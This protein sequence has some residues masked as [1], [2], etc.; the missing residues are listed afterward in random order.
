MDN[1]KKDFNLE[2]RNQET[3]SANGTIT[4]TTYEGDEPHLFVSYALEDE[5]IALNE[6]K[7]FQDMGYY[8]SYDKEKTQNNL[9]KIKKCWAYVVFFT[10]NSAKLN[11][12]IEEVQFAHENHKN[13]LPIFLVETEIDTLIEYELSESNRISK[14][15][16]DIET[17]LSKC[18]NSFKSFGIKSSNDS[19]DS[20]LVPGVG[21]VPFPAFRGEGSYMFISYAHKDSDIVFPEIKRFQDMGYNVWYDEGI[22]A[23]NE[24]LRDVLEHLV[25]SDLFVVFITN[26]SVKSKN[27]RKEIKFAVSKEKNIVP[28]YLENYDEINLDLQLDY[29][30]SQIQGIIKP[31]LDEEEYIFK[32]TEAFENFG[33]KPDYGDI[34]EKIEFKSPQELLMDDAL[35]NEVLYT[36]INLNTIKKYLDEFFNNLKLYDDYTKGYSYKEL[37]KLAIDVFLEKKYMYTA[38]DVYNTFFTI[39]QVNPSDE[40]NKKNINDKNLILDLINVIKNNY[41]DTQ[42]QKNLFIHSVNVFILGLAIYSRNKNYRNA[43][44]SYITGSEYEKYYKI[45]N[46][47]SDEEFLYRWGITSLLH[48]IYYPF[49]KNGKKENIR[50][51]KKLDNLLGQDQV[52]EDTTDLNNLVKKAP[53]DFTDKYV[54]KYEETKS[55]NLFKYTNIIAHKIYHNFKFDEEKLGLL[56]NHINNFLNEIK[57]T[58]FA[59][60]GFLSALL[61]LNAYDYQIQEHD[62]DSDIFFYPIADSAVAIFLQNYYKY[63]LQKEPFNLKLITPSDSPLAYLLILCDNILEFYKP[64]ETIIDNNVNEISISQINDKKLE[65]SYEVNSS[66]YGFGLSNTL[67]FDDILDIYSIFDEGIQYQIGLSNINADKIFTSTNALPNNTGSMIFI[68]EMAKEIYSQYKNNQSNNFNI[69][70]FNKLASEVKVMNF[71]QAKTIP[72]KLQLIGYEIVDADERPCINEFYEDEII[73]LAKIKHEE[74]YEEKI[75]SGWR[76]GEKND[77]EKLTNPYLV[78][79]EKLDMKI[80]EKEIEHIQNIPNLVKSLGLKIVPSKLRLLS[81][82]IYNI[83]CENKFETLLENIKNLNY[84]KDDLI[85][86]INDFSREKEFSK[87]VKNYKNLNYEKY[88]LIIK[89]NDFSG[90]DKF[91]KLL[92]D[93]KNLNYKESDLIIKAI[94]NLFSDE[95]FNAL[96]QNI[97]N[98]NYK[99]ADLIIKTLS[100]LDYYVVDLSN[101]SKE[102]TSFENKDAIY[103]SQ[104]Y[105]DKLSMLYYSLG[106]RYGADYNYKLKTNPYLVEWDK[107]NLPPDY[108]K[109]QIKIFKQLPKL[110]NEL[111]LKI[112][113]NTYAI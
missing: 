31:T 39:Y 13:I 7:C 91:R 9:D 61:V 99:K 6:I 55:L 88:D 58:E 80:Q 81:Y 113:K 27:V 33:F 44:N 22:G 68:E 52:I 92:K 2:K 73:Y 98:L 64:T 63:F 90:E 15:K 66:S 82:K 42:V 45:D 47:I 100:K 65:L 112:I 104:E 101:N 18:R 85:I 51:Y 28:I 79:W 110:L 62:K 35:K 14:Y 26:N 75:G 23:G 109:M 69:L 111:N 46:E 48:E 102:L 12:I 67:L 17:Y 10:E 76:Y 24:W 38:F 3:L 53:Y 103:L 50:I 97:K 70:D 1:E 32:F 4:L 107:D 56:A 106:W 19:Q 29:E 78:P 54:N 60:H 94:Y 95:I 20:K 93:I 87:L 25:D 96:P 40:S 86:K 43:F 49:E 36:D 59:E 21:R 8:V 57:T 41:Y 74:W 77:N 11:R 72:E 71:R 108:A 84:E 16:L 89:I 105:H 83:S 30:L 5:E 37:L 34:F